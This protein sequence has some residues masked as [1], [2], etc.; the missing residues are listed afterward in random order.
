MALLS[1]PISLSLYSLSP[2]SLVPNTLLKCGG[3]EITNAG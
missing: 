1:P 2:I 3:E